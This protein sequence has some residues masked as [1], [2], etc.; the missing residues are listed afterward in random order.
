MAYGER[1]EAAGSGLPGN[2]KGL[3]DRAIIAV[4]CLAAGSAGRRCRRSLSD[5]SSS[6]MAGGASL[7]STEARGGRSSDIAT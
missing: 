2:Q 7:I 1:F 3:R 5:T 6:G 4:C